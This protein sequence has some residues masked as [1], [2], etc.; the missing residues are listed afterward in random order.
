[1][2]IPHEPRSVSDPA[3]APVDGV[4][5]WDGPDR[6]GVPTIQSEE[7]DFSPDEQRRYGN[8]K[9]DRTAHWQVQDRDPA[10]Q[11]CG[12]LTRAES[13]AAG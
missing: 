2:N 6:T 13:A 10:D 9:G 1:M 8:L 4:L 11:A 12:E 7:A 5:R 3:W